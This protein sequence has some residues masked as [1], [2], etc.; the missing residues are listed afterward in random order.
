MTTTEKATSRPLSPHTGI[1]RWSVTMASS[2]LHRFTGIGNA[3]GVFLLTW[4]LVALASGAEAYGQF[5]GFIGS[6]LG[7]FFLF[8]FTLSMVYHMLNGAR[9]LLWD[10]GRG[11]D[12]PTSARN[13]VMIMLLAVLV[14]LG[15]WALGYSMMEGM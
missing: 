15:V 4:W 3:I 13:T 12:V 11:F 1:W 10:A 7:R 9:H 14:T 8:G 6:P 5:L 2:I